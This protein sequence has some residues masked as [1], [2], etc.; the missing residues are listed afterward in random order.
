MFYSLAGLIKAWINDAR[1]VLC[2]RCVQ[3]TGEIPGLG[4]EGASPTPSPCPRLGENGVI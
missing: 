2:P 4:R 3:G 1:S